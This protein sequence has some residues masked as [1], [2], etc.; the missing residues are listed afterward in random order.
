MKISIDFFKKED[1]LSPNAVHRLA[2]GFDKYFP[3]LF[4]YFP[5]ANYSELKSQIDLLLPTVKSSELKM[6]LLHIKEDISKLKK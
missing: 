5:T 6:V 2:V 1:A 3:L 4:K